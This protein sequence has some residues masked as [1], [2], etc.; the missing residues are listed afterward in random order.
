MSEPVEKVT[1]QEQ[2]LQV[3]VKQFGTPT[4]FSCP[5]CNGTLWELVDGELLRYRCRVG[6][7]YSA[8]SIVEAESNAVERSLWEA[9]RTLEESASMSRRIAQKSEI[10]RPHLQN[11]AE[12]R[13]RHAQTIRSL[14]LSNSG[15][16]A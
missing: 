5:D 14:L 16:A 2:G 6:H 3:D 15:E 9:V 13:E 4:A 11:K 12:E 10:L 8:Q 1:G 7:A